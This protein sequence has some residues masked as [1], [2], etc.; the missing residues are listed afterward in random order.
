L[1]PE[2]DRQPYFDK[3]KAAIGWEGPAFAISGSERIGTEELCQAAM[4]R[5]N[6]KREEINAG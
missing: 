3:L 6:Q 2:E 4:F 5:I 1:L